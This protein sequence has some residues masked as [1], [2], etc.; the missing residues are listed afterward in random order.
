MISQVAIPVF[1][2]VSSEVLARGYYSLVRVCRITLKALNQGFDIRGKMIGVFSRC[3]LT[4]A[5]ARV[6]ER[7]DVLFA[8]QPAAH[9][10]NT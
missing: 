8:Y 7:V 2:V 1:N 5:P 6:P 10:M 3:L 9:Q 4:T